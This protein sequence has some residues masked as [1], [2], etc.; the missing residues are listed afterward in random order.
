[1]FINETSTFLVNLKSSHPSK[2]GYSFYFNNL[3]IA[4]EFSDPSEGRKRLPVF[5]LVLRGRDNPLCEAGI[6]TSQVSP[7]TA[8][9]QA[10][11]PVLPKHPNCLCEER[12]DEAI[13]NPRY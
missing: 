8:Q 4:L 5:D 9:A 2:S 13:L 10:G 3:L 11:T 12:S 7:Q 1:V 6:I